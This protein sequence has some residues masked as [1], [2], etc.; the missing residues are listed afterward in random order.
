[1][2]PDATRTILIVDDAE[3]SYTTLELALDEIAG[4]RVAVA[5]SAERALDYL[6][7]PGVAAMITDV[8]LPGMSGWELVANVRANPRWTTLPIIVVSA[9]ADPDAPAKARSAGANAYFTKPFSPSAVRR[10]LEELLE[11]SIHAQ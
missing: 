4:A 5:G 1:M 11:E 8:Q 6:A 9:A 10:R 7:H 2:T 3:E